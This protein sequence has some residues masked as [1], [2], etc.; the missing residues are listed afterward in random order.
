MSRARIS[1][2]R[3]L[4]FLG[5]GFPGVDFVEQKIEEASIF[6]CK[7][8]L[9]CCGG[10]CRPRWFRSSEAAEESIYDSACVKQVFQRAESCRGWQ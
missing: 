1:I 2:A 3:A 10:D 7:D 6:F 9:L 4:V 8:A 5:Q